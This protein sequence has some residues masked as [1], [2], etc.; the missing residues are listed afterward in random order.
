[1]FVRL[2]LFRKL[3]EEAIQEAARMSVLFKMEL[4]RERD[5]VHFYRFFKAIIYISINGHVMPTRGN[6]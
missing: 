4:N 3:M 6:L 2:I 5:S 1:M